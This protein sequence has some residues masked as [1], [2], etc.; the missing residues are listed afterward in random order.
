MPFGGSRPWFLCPANGCNRRAAILYSGGGGFACRRCLGLA[1]RTQHE[2]PDG[3]LLIKAER[4]WARLGW[5]FGEEGPKPKGM[6][7][8][9]FNRIAERAAE[10]HEASFYASRFVQRT[11]RM[12]GS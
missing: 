5:A 2:Q 8:R 10:A 3:R 1:Y 9:T 4:Q 7:W 11:L 12:Q 6:Y